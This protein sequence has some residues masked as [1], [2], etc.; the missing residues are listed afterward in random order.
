M[1]PSSRCIVPFA[2][3][4]IVVCFIKR[5]RH[6]FYFKV[7]ALLSFLLFTKDSSIQQSESRVIAWP[8]NRSTNSL[9][10]L[11]GLWRGLDQ[12]WLKNKVER[13]IANRRFNGQ[14]TWKMVLASA[15]M[16]QTVQPND[17]FQRPRG[18]V[19]V[20]CS[21][22]EKATS[23]PNI[24]FA[25]KQTSA[26]KSQWRRRVVVLNHLSL[27]L[28]DLRLQE[29]RL[30]CLGDLGMWFIGRRPFI[31]SKTMPRC[32][33]KQVNSVVS[34]NNKKRFLSH[35]ILINTPL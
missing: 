11:I 31:Q 27:A 19:L 24:T 6:V 4:L 32:I 35:L 13:L 23:L 25:S 16:D 17:I 34:K 7:G 18:L 1:L 8:C 9:S 10:F 33:C 15:L 28:D 20:Q 22:S 26:H 2:F 14:W 21:S 30:L 3:R 29:D 12:L 5:L